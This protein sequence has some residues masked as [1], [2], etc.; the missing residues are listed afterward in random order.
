[1]FCDKYVTNNCGC[2]LEYA[3]TRRPEKVELNE[4]ECFFDRYELMYIQY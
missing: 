3:A 4:E 1:M 2:F